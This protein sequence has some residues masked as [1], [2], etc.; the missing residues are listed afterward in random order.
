MCHGENMGKNMYIYIYVYI[1]IHKNICI[2][3]YIHIYTYT[4]TYIYI[5]YENGSTAQMD[6]GSSHW[7]DRQM[8][9]D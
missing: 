3:V 5:S 2:Y 7:Q 8:S 4:Y 1:Y 9:P 6:P